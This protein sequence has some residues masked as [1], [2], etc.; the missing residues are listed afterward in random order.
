MVQ[1]GVVAREGA[2]PQE[3]TK[4][5]SINDQ[6]QWGLEFQHKLT[7]AFQGEQFEAVLRMAALTEAIELTLLAATQAFGAATEMGLFQR[8]SNQAPAERT[9]TD[10]PGMRVR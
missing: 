1:G 5:P 7:Q 10:R 4:A 6:V 3:S 9:P 2:K 8:F